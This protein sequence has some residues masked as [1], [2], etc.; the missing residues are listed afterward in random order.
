M[1]SSLPT[2]TPSS[3]VDSLPSSPQKRNA[4]AAE[5]SDQD[6][7]SLTPEIQK[8]I[9]KVVHTTTQKLCTSKGQICVQGPSGERGP[10]GPQGP[11]GPPG[12]PGAP[13]EKGPRGDSEEPTTVNPTSLQ[14]FKGQS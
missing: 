6:N 1:V 14:P 7:S 12:P 3:N 5:A 9:I 8:Q 2:G 4:R 13:G 11:S 10:R